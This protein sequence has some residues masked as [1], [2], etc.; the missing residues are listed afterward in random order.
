MASFEE[1]C[2]GLG[3]AADQVQSLSDTQRRALLAGWKADASAAGDDPP[4][5]PPDM[6]ALLT[7]A[8]AD[9]ARTEAVTGLVARYVGEFPRH[10][11]A[12]EQ[13]GRLATAGAWTPSEP[14]WNCCGWSAP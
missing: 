5:D 12:I 10:L 6:E 4:A 2:S 14:N 1:W 9:R 7:R 13:V 8:R 11:Q 3:W